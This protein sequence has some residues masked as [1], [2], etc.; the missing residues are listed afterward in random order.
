MLLL[1]S[2]AAI[3]IGAFLSETAARLFGEASLAPFMGWTGWLSAGQLLTQISAALLAFGAFRTVALTQMGV[4]TVY[5]VVL[6]VAYFAH[7]RGLWLGLSSQLVLQIA[8]GVLFIVL[9]ARAWRARGLRPALTRFGL[10]LRELLRLGLPMHLASAVPALLGLL[11]ASNLARNAG[12]AALADLRVVTAMGQLVAFLPAAMAVT[13]LTELT[14]AR[15]SAAQVKSTDFMRYIRVVVASAAIAATTAAWA[16]NWLVPLIFGG[17]YASAVKL[18]SLGVATATVN[19]TKQAL[20]VG[21]IS[22]RK[23]GYALMDSLLSSA[24]YTAFAMSLTPSWGVT[25]ILISD[26]LGQSV[27]LIV[28]SVLLSGRFKQPDTRKQALLTLLALALTLA[29]LVFAFAMHEHTLGPIVYTPLLIGV[30]LGAPWLLFTREER[31]ALMQLLR[32]R[33]QRA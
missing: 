32:S 15:G 19:A 2:A 14:G 20:I 11:V 6:A 17:T 12:L 22:E 10:A 18:V 3:G 23:T 25:G 28:F 4:S 5:L 29:A 8:P 21:L 33:F 9:T 16:A 24:L 1:L 13:F 7:V 26:L 27:P 30:S 31:A